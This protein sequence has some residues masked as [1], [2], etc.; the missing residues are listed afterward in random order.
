[1]VSRDPATT[2]VT[3][4]VV[5]RH[6][7]ARSAVAREQLPRPGRDSAFGCVADSKQLA[8]YHLGI[9]NKER[10]TAGS[11]STRSARRA[12]GTVAVHYQEQ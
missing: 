1:V 7:A 3:Q 2:F 4:G 11:P 6:A 5:V 10:L 12:Q 9:R 8:A